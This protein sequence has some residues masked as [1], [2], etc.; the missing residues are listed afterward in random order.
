ME[1]KGV[2]D[3]VRHHETAL[4]AASRNTGEYTAG[5]RALLDARTQVASDE[6]VA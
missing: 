5:L 3:N 1:A 4:L 6:G 2:R